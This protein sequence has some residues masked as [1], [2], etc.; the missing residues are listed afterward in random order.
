MDSTVLRNTMILA[1]SL[2]NWIANGAC[3]IDRKNLSIV[4]AQGILLSIHYSEKKKHICCENARGFFALGNELLS[5]WHFVPLLTWLF[6]K[7]YCSCKDND[8]R[9][10]CLLQELKTFK[11]WCKFITEA[12]ELDL[13]IMLITAVNGTR[14]Y[15]LKSKL[16][17][18]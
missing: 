9:L 3:S 11:E 1:T 14:H 18:I 5:G 4:L 6:P 10:T 2:I 16:S 17:Q 8:K 15:T 7:S 13:D 12:S